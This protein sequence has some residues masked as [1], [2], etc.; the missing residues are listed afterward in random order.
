MWQLVVLCAALAHDHGQDFR[1]GWER[2]KARAAVHERWRHGQL[3]S[4]EYQR[5][6]AKLMTPQEEAE[7][8]KGV[9]ERRKLWDQRDKD[10]E[11][12]IRRAKEVVERWKAKR[13]VGP[14]P[15]PDMK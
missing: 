1:A 4:E 10:R 5:A 6:W 11:A 14:P 2:A 13:L 8:W 15:P 3:S 9:Q 12:N 7:F